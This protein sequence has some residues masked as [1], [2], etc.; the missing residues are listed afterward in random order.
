LGVIR[1]DRVEDSECKG[2]EEAVF[3]VCRDETGR[4]IDGRWKREF[5]SALDGT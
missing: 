5:K 2:N 3:G 1:R 4:G